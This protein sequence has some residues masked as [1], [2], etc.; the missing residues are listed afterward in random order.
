MIDYEKFGE[1]EKKLLEYE[2]KKPGYHS[3]FLLS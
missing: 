1:E 2:G 3:G